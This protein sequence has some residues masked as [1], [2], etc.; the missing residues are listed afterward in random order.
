MHSVHLVEWYLHGLV[1]AATTPKLWSLI[2]YLAHITLIQCFLLLLLVFIGKPAKN[3]LLYGNFFLF[4]IWAGDCRVCRHFWF[5]GA[6]EGLFGFQHSVS[7][8]LLI[9][10][11]WGPRANQA[12]VTADAAPLLREVVAR[13][14]QQ[15]ADIF[16]DGLTVLELRELGVVL[17][18]FEPDASEVSYLIR[19]EYLRFMIINVDSG[20]QILFLGVTPFS[21]TP[22]S[23]CVTVFAGVTTHD[24]DA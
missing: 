3:T 23:N 6:L 21:E 14:T 20:I 4:D 16:F 7:G 11:Y 1:H 17:L 22:W 18:D 15:L 13:D 10:L 8:L 24:W 19:R 5:N 2:W 12:V 9:L